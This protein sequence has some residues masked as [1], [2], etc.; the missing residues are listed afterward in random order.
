MHTCNKRAALLVMSAVKLSFKLDDFARCIAMISPRGRNGDSAGHLRQNGGLAQLSSPA[1]RAS[2]YVR[3]P[4]SLPVTGSRIGVLSASRG[5]TPAK[6]SARLLSAA[7][8]ASVSTPGSENL[9]A[10]AAAVASLLDRATIFDLCAY[11]GATFK[12]S[13]AAKP[14]LATLRRALK[15]VVL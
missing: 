6:T 8:N 11:T 15:A 10:L 14:R 13:A 1:A 4:I 9:K 2:S 12:W 5:V 3:P 7:L